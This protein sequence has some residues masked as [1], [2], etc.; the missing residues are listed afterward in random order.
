[1]SEVVKEIRFNHSLLEGTGMALKL[2][3][4]ITCDNVDAIFMAVNSSSGV[5]IRHIDTR[6][7]FVREYV[8]DGFIKLVFV[9]SEEND[10]DIFQRILDCITK[11]QCSIFLG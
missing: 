1:L 2:P 6:Y 8:E 10:V 7:Y 3:I 5:R 9:K 4:I 11:I